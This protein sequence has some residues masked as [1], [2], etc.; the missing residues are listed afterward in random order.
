MTRAPTW[1]AW[2]ET[3]ASNTHW[4]IYLPTHHGPANGVRCAWKSFRLE[5][6][7]EPRSFTQPIATDITD[8]L[9]KF[10]SEFPDRWSLQQRCAQNAQTVSHRQSRRS[11][12]LRGL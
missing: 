2:R 5:E 6:H 10:S 8:P 3:F 1:N 9:I 4:V 11:S 12:R 7:P